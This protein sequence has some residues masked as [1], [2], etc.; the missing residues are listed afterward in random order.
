MTITRL[1]LTTAAAVALLAP[2]GSA[3]AAT[4]AADGMP[5]GEWPFYGGSYDNHRNQTA[6][7]TISTS[8]ATGLG[9]HRKLTM[10]DGGIIHSV[11]TV[12]DGC[13]FTGTNAG[14]AYALNADTLEVVWQR[15]VGESDGGNFAEGAGVVGAPAVANGRVFVPATVT[16]GPDRGAV[17]TALDQATGAFLWKTKIDTD[18]GAGLDSSPVPLPFDG[19]LFQAFKGDESSNHSRPGWAF[20]DQATGNVVK[21]VHNINDADYAAGY[22][23]GSMINTPAVDVVNKLIYGGTGNPASVKQHPTTNSLIQIDADPASPTFGEILRKH[24][25]TSDSYP[26]PQDV[27]PPTCRS[28]TQWPV[29]RF[30][31]GQF[32]YN[33]LSSPAVWENSQGREIF[34]GVQKSGVFTA[35]YTDTF[36]QAFQIPLGPPCVACNL[37]SIAVDESGVYVATTGGALYSL[38]KDTGIPQWALGGTGSFRMNGLTVANGVLYSMNDTLGT[39][40]AFDTKTGAPAGAVSFGLENQALMHEMGNSSGISV[41]RN[42]VF[43]SAQEANGGSTL[44]ALKL[45]AGGGGGGGPV[46]PPDVPAAGGVVATGPSG[47]ATGFLPPVVTI[48]QGS[49]LRYVNADIVAH[50]VVSVDGLFTSGP[51][52][53]LSERPVNGV[54]DLDPGTYEFLCQPHPGMTGQL[55]VQ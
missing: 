28:E 42:T 39:L 38:N 31:C 33:F 52:T 30:S 32:D 34:G 37:S 54:E 2:A 29:G 18:A 1:A 12:V 27:D 3:Q 22:R 24:R 25:G 48:P 17:L 46:E 23:G 15:K 21:K 19:L 6:E 43:A 45:G 44:F 53:A 4:C 13:V 11:P 9:V 16:G 51:P 49:G 35:V 50:N 10:P 55:I 5:G 40:Q 41:A 26:A 20:I 47:Q 8:N 7:S 36:Q 14:N